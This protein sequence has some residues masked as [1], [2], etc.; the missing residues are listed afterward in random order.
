LARYAYD[1]DKVD[2]SLRRMHDRLKHSPWSHER[3]VSLPCSYV[4]RSHSLAE[5]GTTHTY[6]GTVVV[7]I[8]LT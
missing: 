6:G 2:G 8:I 7:R 5:R 3:I 1:G 4:Y